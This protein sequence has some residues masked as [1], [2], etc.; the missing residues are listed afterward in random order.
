GVP[1][2]QLIQVM[3]NGS[4][5]TQRTVQMIRLLVSVLLLQ[6]AGGGAELPG[7]QQRSTGDDPG[8]I[9][10][11]LRLEGQLGLT[12]DQ[13]DRLREIDVRMDGVSQPLVDRLRGCRARI[14]A[15][16]PQRE[17]TP[18]SRALFD[19]YVAEARP[20]MREVGANN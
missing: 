5:C 7:Q 13:V 20:L 15:L 10:T 6:L 14:R 3:G 11:R 16:G 19:S 9:T 4:T 17:M 1:L 12:G 8:P 18:E 2:P